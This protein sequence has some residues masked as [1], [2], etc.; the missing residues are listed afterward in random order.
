MIHYLAS[1]KFNDLKPQTVLAIVMADQVYME[2]GV[3]EMWLTSVDDKVHSRGSKHYTGYAIDIRVHNI[4]PSK[5]QIIPKVLKARLSPGFDVL[6]EGDHIHVE[7]DP[8]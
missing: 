1:V 3:M 6:D 4:I 8:K 7:Y 2:H 5:R